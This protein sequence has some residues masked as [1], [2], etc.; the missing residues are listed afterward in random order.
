MLHIDRKCNAAL[1]KLNDELCTFE[2]VTGQQYTLILIP[3]SPKE[4]IQI[5]E[6]GKPLP[7]KDLGI[8]PENV[9]AGAMVKRMR[10]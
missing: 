9:M 4:E 2:R 6:N 10:L 3:H 8:I 7:F 5:S 1:I